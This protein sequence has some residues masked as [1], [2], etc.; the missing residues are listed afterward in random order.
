MLMHTDR[1]IRA[2]TQL[3]ETYQESSWQEEEAVLW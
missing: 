1:Q 2:F 3:F